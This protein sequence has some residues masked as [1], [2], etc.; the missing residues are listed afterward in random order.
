MQHINRNNKLISRRCLFCALT[1]SWQRGCE[2]CMCRCAPI[3]RAMH[4]SGYTHTHAHSVT[5]GCPGL[6]RPSRANSNTV[7]P[8]D[9]GETM[10]LRNLFMRIR[11]ISSDKAPPHVRAPRTRFLQG[12]SSFSLWVFHHC[13]ITV[14]KQDKKQTAE[15]YQVQ[16]EH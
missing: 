3:S 5:A 4:P 14:S 10:A 13:I 6:G 2:D 11:L 9:L 7:I 16:Q 1:K 12:S 8:A 15:E